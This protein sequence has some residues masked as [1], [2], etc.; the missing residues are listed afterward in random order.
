VDYAHPLARDVNTRRN[1]RWRESR[2]T[3]KRRTRGDF[4]RFLRR[5]LNIA[6]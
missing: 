4:V 2:R 5:M 6:D 3:A 1:Q